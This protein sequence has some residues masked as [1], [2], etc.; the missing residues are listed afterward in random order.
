MATRHADRARAFVA[1]STLAAALLAGG[2]AS[3]SPFRAGQRAE[4]AQDYDRAVVEYTKAV[5][6]KP[7]DRTTRL[8]LDRARVRASQE[9]YYRGRRLEAT[10]HFEEDN[11]STQ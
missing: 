7:D 5:R 4:D 11:S 2:C 8:T 1:S 6:A 3:S 10:E 9:H